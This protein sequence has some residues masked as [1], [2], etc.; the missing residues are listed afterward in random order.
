MGLD[1]AFDRKKAVSAGIVMKMIPNGDAES[2]A[3][4]EADE[5]P[6]PDYI[7]WLKA[8]EP[9]IQVPGMTGWVSDGGGKDDFIVRANRWG[10]VYGPLTDWLRANDIQWDEF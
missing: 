4:A 5:C 1:I 2:I 7:A 6:D 10:F 3:R 8:E 9:C